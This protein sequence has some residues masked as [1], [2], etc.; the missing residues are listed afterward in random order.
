MN[1]RWM[2]SVLIVPITNV[3]AA[4]ASVS[5]SLKDGDS[6]RRHQFQMRVN[7]NQILSPASDLHGYDSV[8]R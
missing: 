2:V 1:W 7:T 6:K 4:T 3:T 8:M 5:T